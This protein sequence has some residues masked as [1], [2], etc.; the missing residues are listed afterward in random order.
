MR[1]TVHIIGI[2]SPFGDDRLGW[3]AAEA[4][5][6]SFLAGAGELGRITISVLDRPGALLLA[7]FRW[8]D[9]VIVLDAVRSGA[10]PGTCHRFDDTGN[11]PAAGFPASSHG[12]GVV[13]ALELARV[14]GNLPS[15]LLLRGIEIDPSCGGLSMSKTVMRVMP[16]F[17]REIEATALVLARSDVALA[18]P[19][20]A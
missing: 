11:L 10:P 14:L 20:L 6:R 2:G 3:A 5:Q 13:A 4:L 18:A 9:S 8:A 1:P 15:R 7:E 19:N 17:V 12:F 16:A